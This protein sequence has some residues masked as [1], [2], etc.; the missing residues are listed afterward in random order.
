MNDDQ[1]SMVETIKAITGCNDDVGER[2]LRAVNFNP[3]AAF[4]LI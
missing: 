1:K 4:D 2:A 3:D